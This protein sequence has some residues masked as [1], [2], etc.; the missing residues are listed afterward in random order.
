MVEVK[1]QIVDLAREMVDVIADHKGADILLLDVREHT[2]I[3]DYFIICSA[4]SER[5]LR[6]VVESIREEVKDNHRIIPLSVE[7][8]SNS[9][10]V[11]MD[12]ADIII[13]VFSPEMR[14]FYDLEGFWREAAVLLKMQ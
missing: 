8:E 9:G 11:L 4:Q 13:H 7:G 2:I 1:T 12:Y 14:A 10:W 6:A 5:Q 3:A